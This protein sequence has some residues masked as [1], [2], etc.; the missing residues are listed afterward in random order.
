MNFLKYIASFIFPIRIEYRTSEINGKVEVVHINGKYVLDSAHANY[1]FGGLHRV[2]QT[3][4]SQ[5]KIKDRKMDSALILGFGGGSVAS[6]LQKEYGKKIKILGVEKDKEIIDLARKYFS[7]D[8]YKNLNLICHD[9]REFVFN[10]D[11]KFDLIVI[12][13]FVD[14]NVP[15]EF[16]EEKFLSRLKNL[17]SEKGILFFNL[18]VYNEKVRNKGAKLYNDLNLLVGKTDWCRIH[19]KRTENWVFVSQK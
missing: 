1:S 11:K 16:T 17:I 15:D 3:A 2:F 9:A 6:I 19:A 8:E 7:I 18:V 13:V 4:F 5:F 10:C 12:D 14:R